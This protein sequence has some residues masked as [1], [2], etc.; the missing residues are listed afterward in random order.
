VSGKTPLHEGQRVQFTEGTGR[1]G[2]GHVRRM[3][4]CK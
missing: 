3:S 4:H 2:G 1:E